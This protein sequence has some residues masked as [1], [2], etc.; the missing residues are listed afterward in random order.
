MKHATGDDK[1]LQLELAKNGEIP[2]HVAIIMDGNGRWAERRSLPRIAGHKA[3]VDSVRDIVEVCGQLGVKYLTLYAFSTENWK[4]PPREVSVLMQLL[5]HYLRSEVA[6]LKDN[7]V[8]LEAIGQIN[9]LPKRVQKQLFTSIDALKNST[10]MQLTLALS[11]SGRWDLTRA[12]QTLAFDVR[13]GKIS[14]E[15]VDE[16]LIRSFLSTAALP[17]PDL[18]VRTSGEMRVS[19]F[20]LWEIAYSEIVV[21]ETLWPEFRRANLYA[22][23]L[24]YQKRERRFGMTGA[25]RKRAHAATPSYVQRMLNALVG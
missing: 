21:T 6:E 15:S 16:D 2:A 22:A 23:I 8:R 25:Q 17:D 11:Y 14:P 4:R 24:E 19:N 20:L 7:N 12:I 3:G 1:R 9:A 5:A 18:V 13:R 10:G